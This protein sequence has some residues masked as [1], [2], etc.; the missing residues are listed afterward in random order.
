MEE[1]LSAGERLREDGFFDEDSSGRS[2]ADELLEQVI[3]EVC[4]DFEER[5]TRHFGYLL[6]SL[7]FRS[8]I[9]SE[10]GH[11]LAALAA[12]LTYGQLVL[13][14]L[15]HQTPY[16]TLPLW[17]ALHPFDYQ[18]HAVAG[19]VFDLAVRGVLFRT[20]GH[21]V[22]EYSEADPARMRVGVSGHLLFELMHLDRVSAEDLDRARKQV[23]A[24]AD[25][26]APM[27]LS[28]AL[29][30]AFDTASLAETDVHEGHIRI[31]LDE[32]VTGLLPAPGSE[33]FVMLRG[34]PLAVRYELESDDV[35]VSMSI[36]HRIASD[37]PTP[38]CPAPAC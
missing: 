37:S 24:V 13:V 25:T 27:E 19:Q 1:R 35:G 8:D 10:H 23:E 30:D 11:F 5:K 33:P 7:A 21:P 22:R 12:D 4:D 26:P 20:D 32:R 14:S 31:P 3:H 38:P 9:G 29:R 34:K 36:S 17:E 18:S 15:L 16:G 2:R 28:G 6:A